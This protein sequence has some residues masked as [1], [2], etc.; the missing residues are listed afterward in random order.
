MTCCGRTY[1]EVSVAR[2]AHV[3]GFGEDIAQML[4]G[5]LNARS[6]VNGD[7]PA[8]GEPIIRAIRSALDGAGVVGI[9][10]SA[11]ARERVTVSRTQGSDQRQKKT[12]QD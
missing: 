7:H 1:P 3:T 11:R 5:T 6:A 10:T 4:P 2:V 12:M 9:S 8:R